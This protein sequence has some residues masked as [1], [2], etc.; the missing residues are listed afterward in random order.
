MLNEGGY[1]LKY[2]LR[3]EPS[4]RDDAEGDYEG[5]ND[6][7]PTFNVIAHPSKDVA[8]QFTEACVARLQGK[9]IFK[10][11]GIKKVKDDQKFIYD[12]PTGVEDNMLCNPRQRRHCYRTYNRSRQ[13][14]RRL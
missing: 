11:L 1:K 2:S 7:S 12:V 8:K 14:S 9:N 5:G 6:P 13:A 3:L 10:A 4:G